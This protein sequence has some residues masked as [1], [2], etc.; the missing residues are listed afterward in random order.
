[1]E[2][3]IR[4]SHAALSGYDVLL[5]QTGMFVQCHDSSTA[6]LFHTGRTVV[7]RRIKR[8]TSK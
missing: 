3:S 5:L 4:S 1:M 7:S 2:I 6:K 8:S